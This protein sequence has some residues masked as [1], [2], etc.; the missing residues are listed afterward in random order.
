MPGFLEQKLP[1]VG[2]DNLM[3]EESFVG[4]GALM[5]VVAV[6]RPGVEADKQG[7]ETVMPGK[8]VDGELAVKSAEPVDRV[9]QL[10]EHRVVV[11]VH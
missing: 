3:D 7:I 11:E 8:D 9:A 10:D 4:M 5:V 2:V 1:E 6:V